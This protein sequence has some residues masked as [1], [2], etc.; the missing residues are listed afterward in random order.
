MTLWALGFEASDSDRGEIKTK[1]QAPVL[2]LHNGVSG[3]RLNDDPDLKPSSLAQGP[4]WACSGP[5]RSSCLWVKRQCLSFI[6]VLFH[7]SVLI[8]LDL[9]VWELK[10]KTWNISEAKRG[11]SVCPSRSH[12]DA[13]TY[14]PNKRHDSFQADP[15]YYFTFI[16]VVSSLWTSGIGCKKLASPKNISIR[17]PWQSKRCPPRISY[18]K[19]NVYTYTYGRVRHVSNGSEWLALE[20]ECSSRWIRG[21]GK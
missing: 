6:T 12:G 18:I 13:N 3:L 19:C 8:W 10:Q 16:H 7:H 21:Y 2:L 1:V 5:T 4:S 20:A 11:S 14:I 17:D 15:W 9:E